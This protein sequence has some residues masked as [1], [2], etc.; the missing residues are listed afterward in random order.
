MRWT[1]ERRARRCGMRRG[2]FNGDDTPLFERYYQRMESWRHAMADGVIKP[3]EI[4]AQAKRVHDMLAAV[5]S[6]LS[7]EQHEALTAA[8]CEMAALEGMHAHLVSQQTDA[9]MMPWRDRFV[10][11]PSPDLQAA[12][13]AAANALRARNVDVQVI[14]DGDGYVVRA[15]N[16]HPHSS[17]RW[18][19]IV[20]LASDI[21]VAVRPAPGG[22][23][24]RMNLGDWRDKIV[25]GALGLF[26]WWPWLATGGAGLY[27]EYSLMRDASQALDAYAA[28]CQ[29]AGDGQSAG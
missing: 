19:L 27:H 22:F 28:G 15:T 16:I 24:V 29:Q 2:W 11:C 3:E 14:Q 21:N 17:D 7:D 26:L 4:A 8:L 9:G 6:T 13:E 10:P 25:A 1:M 5:E 12:S 20:G 23:T 18:R